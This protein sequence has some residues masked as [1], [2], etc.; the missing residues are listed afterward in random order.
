MVGETLSRY[1]L[2]AHLGSGAMGDVYRA[3]DQRL[4]R[5][6]ALKVVRAAR[7]PEETS[8]RLLAEARAGS[9][10]THPNIAVVY[11]VDEVEHDGATLSFIAMEYVAGRTLADLTSQGPLPLDTILDVGRQV[12]D[13][14]AAAHAYGLVHRDI[15]PSNIMVTDSGLA[16]VLDFGVAHW[17]APMVDTA[18]T[19]TVDPLQ[20]VAAGT[21]SYMSPEQSTGRP[22]DGRSDMFSL[23]VVLYELLAGH[24]LFEGAN[25]PQVLE[26][27]LQKEAPP[28]H[29]R[30]DDPRLPAVERVVRRML[31]K[32]PLNR[33]DDLEAVGLALAAAQRGDSLQG[34]RAGTASPILAVTDFL[35]ISANPEDDWLG[36][37]ISETVTADLEGFEGVTVVPRG[38]VS[39]LART[40]E[41][42]GSDSRDALWIRVGRELGA[43]WVL[44]GS[45]QRA[46]DAVRVTAQL[47]DAA[48]ALA[49][50]TIKVDGR[51]QEIFALQDRLVRDLAGLL[52]AVIRPTGAATL[53]TGVVG[54]YEAFSK[55]V[56]N[57]R[58]ESYESLDRAVMLF[59]RAVDLDPGYARAHL[60]LGVAY[61]TKADYLARGELRAHA[62]TSLRRA[63]ELQPDSVRAWR[64]LGS[65]LI[66]TG[67]DGD[68]FDA[69]RR[70]LAIDSADA[71]ALGAMGRALFIGRA[72]FDEAASW[73]ERALAA[74]PQAGWY[75]LQLAHCAALL[76]DFVRGEAA[77]SRAIEL[78]HAAL[79]GQEGVL[80]VGASMRLGHLLALQ[81]RTVE[82]VAAY[83][84]ELTFLNGID[85]ALRNR[86]IVE[87]N[88]RL[89]AAHLSLGETRKGEALLDVAIEAF[90]RRARLGADEP[91]T[92][93][94]AAAAHALRGDADTAIAFLERAATS[95]R[96]FTL[97]RARIEPEFAALR[98]DLRMQRLLY[99]SE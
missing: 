15:K 94:Y 42:Q 60:E 28:L 65:V 8:R 25:A 53:E 2:V 56:L 36:T 68:G 5:T 67:Q 9:A 51:M 38:R 37:G 77:A 3:E 97:E 82:A 4:R 33:F 78:Q 7:D 47:L 40:F 41:R 54:A 35:N 10:F 59:E 87:L 95:R 71:G 98:N 13:A 80:I 52:R 64:E 69:L 32:N 24:R 20:G 18:A 79:S 90:E 66:A 21:L 92:R 89:G 39:E 26:A 16:K 57:L 58:A 48:T 86:V 88:V 62:V 81:G 29:V 76:R 99:A 22:L 84:Q 31:E 30:L 85:H 27:L 12:A 14:L 93:Y 43:R 55:G 96:A 11:E 75:A 1:R 63:L 83:M 91:F 70:A 50:R 44:T 74:N 61:A 49:E 19:E 73:Y 72:Q 45:F 23:G 34:S 46:G 17:S 6:V